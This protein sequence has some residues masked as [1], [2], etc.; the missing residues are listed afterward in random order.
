MSERIEKRVRGEHMLFSSCPEGEETQI[1]DFENL[2]YADC[3][4]MDILGHLSLMTQVIIIWNNYNSYIICLMWQS[5][6]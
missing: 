1:I 5:L 6:N 3:V 2:A 4:E